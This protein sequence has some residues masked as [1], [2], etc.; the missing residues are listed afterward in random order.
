LLGVGHAPVRSDTGWYDSSDATRAAGDPWHGRYCGSPM[1][2]AASTVDRSANELDRDQIVAAAIRI[3]DRRGIAGLSM[4]TLGEELGRSPMAAY[5][6]VANKDEILALTMDVTLG[7]VP[8]VVGPWDVRLRSQLRAMWDIFRA[9]PWLIEV[10]INR[11]EEAPWVI[12]S[13]SRAMDMFRAAGFGEEDAELATVN[14]FAFI[15]GAV[16]T[17]KEVHRTVPEGGGASHMLPIDVLFEFE[18]N[19]YIDGLKASTGRVRRSPR[20]SPKRR[21]V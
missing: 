8:D 12:N 6:H 20:S 2:D 7:S 5:R 16:V 3:L 21:T 15:V 11:Q 10:A 14:H 18:L 13:R 9:H 19:V 1:S 17:S 4:R